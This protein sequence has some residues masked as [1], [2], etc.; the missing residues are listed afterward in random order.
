MILGKYYMKP[1]S[2]FLAEQQQEITREDLKKLEKA[3]DV[4]FGRINIDVNFTRHFHDRANDKRNDKPINFG[5]LTDIFKKTYLKY[6][7][8]LAKHGPDFEAVLKDLNTNI[9]IPFVLVW[10]RRNQELD[11]IAKT[12]MRKKNFKTSNKVLAVQ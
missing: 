8:T 7:D 5:E 10:D 11:L 2:V 6:K 3:L 4:L 12:V 1:F 9:N